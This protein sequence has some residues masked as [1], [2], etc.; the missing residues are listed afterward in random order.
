MTETYEELRTQLQVCYSRIEA[1]KHVKY[2]TYVDLYNQCYAVLQE[3]L[4]SIKYILNKSSWNGRDDD[5]EYYASEY[6]RVKTKIA[7]LESERYLYA[8]DI[9]GEEQWE[10]GSITK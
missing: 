4:E 7:R 8:F 6:V 10:E 9:I 5:N 3:E 2:D 1:D